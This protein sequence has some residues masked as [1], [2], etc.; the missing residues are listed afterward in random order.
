MLAIR[1][2]ACNIMKHE[3]SFNFKQGSKDRP[4]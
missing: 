2:K 4:R 1:V 3:S